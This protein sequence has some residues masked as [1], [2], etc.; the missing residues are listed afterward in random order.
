MGRA[1]IAGAGMPGMT[2]SVVCTRGDH[3]VTVAVY[4]SV[5]VSVPGKAASP[6]QN[7]LEADACQEQQHHNKRK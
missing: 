4:H 5:T 7:C 3:R 2:M 1:R 6:G